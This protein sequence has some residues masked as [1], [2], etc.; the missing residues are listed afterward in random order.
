MELRS[1]RAKFVLTIAG[2]AFIFLMG[3]GAER[4]ITRAER[5]GS[6]DSIIPEASAQGVVADDIPSIV[7][8]TV[9]AVVNISSKRVTQVSRQANPLFDDPFFRRFFGDGYSNV[10]RERVERFLGSGVIV[11][12]DGYILTNNHLV[13]NATEVEVVMPPPDNRTLDAK[14]VGTDART[15]VAVLKVDAKGLPFI[16]FGDVGELRLGQTVLA[17]GYPFQV[18]QTVTM[19]IVS[20]LA[21]AVNERMVDVDLIQTDAAINPGNSGGALINTKGELIGIN[22]MIISNTGS[23]AGL[24][25]AIPIDVAQG[26]MEDIVKHGKVIRGY[27]GIR[28]D[29]LTPDKAEFFD[30]KR[31]EGVI[32]TAVE[33]GSP[34]SKAG[35][36]TNDIITSVNGKEVKNMGELRRSIS[37]IHPGE[38]AEFQILR[39]GKSTSATVT[40]ARRP[41]EPEEAA[42]APEEEKGSPELA[43]LTGVALTDLND[44]FRQRLELPDDL[45][46]VLVTEV[47]PNT[48]AEEAGLDRGDVIVAFNL[49]PVEN[50]ASFKSI[51]KGMKADKFM[52]TVHRGGAQTNIV[53]KE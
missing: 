13:Q 24:G 10:P 15:D 21:K 22:N 4:I 9:P 1:T 12:E 40:V 31:G 17:I 23:Y 47:E 32:V 2:L 35:L 5:S 45:K 30:V 6:G 53:I 19:G 18:G 25:F 7:E 41:D 38:K 11:T 16:K 37:A 50:L 43:L 26:V 14:V 36:Q 8:R 33:K 39:G 44:E 28:M 27:V 52:L 51:I 46:G 48:P 20:G 3:M 29:D 42:Q 34:A 49:K